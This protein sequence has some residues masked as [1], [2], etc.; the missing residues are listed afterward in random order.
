MLEWYRVGAGYR[1]VMEDTK[2][3][4]QWAAR[5]AVG[6]G[7]ARFGRK[8]FD[9]AGPWQEA[10]SGRDAVI[11]LAGAPIADR[12]WTDAY[13]RTI[14][15][16]RVSSTKHVVDA[17]EQASPRPEVFLSASATGYYGDTGPRPTDETGRPAADFSCYA[18]VQ[19]GRDD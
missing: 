9:F 3:V 10:M 8:V 14:R 11:H 5:A 19:P 18:V 4:F 13:K 12:R 16:S 15:E 6:E 7:K 17:L 2:K 1:E